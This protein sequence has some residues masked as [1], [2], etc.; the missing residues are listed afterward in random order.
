MMAHEKNRGTTEKRTALWEFTEA[1]TLRKTLLQRAGRHYTAPAA[2][3]RS[4]MSGNMAVKEWS[5]ALS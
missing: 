2:C 1:N 5:F 4:R 3:L